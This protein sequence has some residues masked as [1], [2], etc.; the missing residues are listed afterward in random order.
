M[1]VHPDARLNKFQ[2]VKIPS[3]IE[4]MRQFGLKLPNSHDGSNGEKLLEPDNPNGVD[5]LDNL[6][7]GI[8]QLNYEAESFLSHDASN[9]PDT[10]S[11]PSQ[12]DDSSSKNE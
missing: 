12:P 6:Q 4:L 1:Y 5:N 10:E 2:L 8:S 9:E 11:E 7:G 3:N